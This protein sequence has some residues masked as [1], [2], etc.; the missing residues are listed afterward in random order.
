MS[1]F[2]KLTNCNM[3]MSSPSGDGEK[4]KRQ[5]EALHERRD[6]VRNERCD[7]LKC[8][9]ISVRGEDGPYR[10]GISVGFIYAASATDEE[11]GENLWSCRD[12]SRQQRAAACSC[13]FSRREDQDHHAGRG[14]LL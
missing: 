12:S 9:T 4:E 2:L 13:L 11:K 6:D 3:I 14:A 1:T 8:H 5:K 10:G 7:S